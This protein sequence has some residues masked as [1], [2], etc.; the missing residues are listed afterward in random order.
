[1]PDEHDLYNLAYNKYMLFAGREVRIGKNCAR[2]L[3]PRAVLKTDG[4]VFSYT[5]RP[6]P[7]NNIFTFFLSLFVFCFVL[8]FK[9]PGKIVSQNLCLYTRV[10]SMLSRSTG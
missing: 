1:M 4:T 3:R 7:A 8:F 10:I 9:K 5:D 2:G 6:R